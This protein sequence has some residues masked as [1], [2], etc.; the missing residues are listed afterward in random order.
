MT[1]GLPQGAPPSLVLF[2]MYIDE[3]SNELQAIAWTIGNKGAAIMVADDVL[4]KE[5]SHSRLKMLLDCATCW[6]GRSD[7]K[8]FIEK[9]TYDTQGARNEYHEVY[10]SWR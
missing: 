5:T 10:C 1:R 8:R 6:Q 9:R 7:S 2:N 3:L 4:L